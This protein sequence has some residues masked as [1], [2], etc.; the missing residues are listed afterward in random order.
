MALPKH[1]KIILVIF[2]ASLLFFAVYVAVNFKKSTVLTESFETRQQ[3]V[4][5]VA[6]FHATWCGHCKDYNKSGVFERTSDI[7]SKDETLKNKV[8]FKKYE[9]DE[10]KDLAN[11]CGINA[12]PTIIIMDSKNKK[13]AEFEGDIYSSTKLIEFA[14]VNA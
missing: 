2:L 8:V 1:Y 9:Y 5:T 10:N 11:K 14:K 6:L 3:D 7:C 13:I 12:F 4:K